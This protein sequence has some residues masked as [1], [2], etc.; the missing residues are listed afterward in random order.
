[1]KLAEALIL[2]KDLQNRMDIMRERLTM[3][4]RVQEG[5]EPAENPLSLIQ[6]MEEISQQLE[7]LI[8][9]INLTNAAVTENGQTIS[10]MLAHRECLKERLSILESTLS[11]A[12]DLGMRGMRSEVKILSTVP[13]AQLRKKTD[14][15]SVELRECNTKIQSLNWLTELQ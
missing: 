12:N 13:I 4:A 3:N 2:R 14:R 15:L 5:E 1:M 7:N 8:T 11:C 6:E 10:A 9:R